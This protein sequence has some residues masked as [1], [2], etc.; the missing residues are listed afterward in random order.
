MLKD[1]GRAV[2]LL[3][4]GDAER[5]I[6]ASWESLGY[7]SHVNAEVRDLWHHKDLGKFTAKFSRAGA[8]AWRGNGDS[9]TLTPSS[10]FF[11]LRVDSC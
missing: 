8:I 6:S 5:E 9:E 1:G 11:G 10:P 7:P 3:N 4:R 2:L